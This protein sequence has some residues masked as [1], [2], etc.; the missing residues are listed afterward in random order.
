MSLSRRNFRIVTGV[1]FF[2]DA[3][4]ARSGRNGFELNPVLAVEFLD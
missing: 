2:D 1:G 4:A 3:L